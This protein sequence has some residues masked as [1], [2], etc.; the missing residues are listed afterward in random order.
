MKIRT[1]QL[2]HLQQQ[3]TARAKAK[4]ETG[5]FEDLLASEVDKAAD[6]QGVQQTSTPPPGA[7]LGIESLLGVEAL[8]ATDAITPSEQSVMENIDTVLDK[9]ETYAENLNAPES[10]SGL[11]TA[12]GVLQNISDDVQ[13]LKDAMP[14]LAE[15]RPDLQGLVDELEILTVTEQFKFNRGD[16]L[17]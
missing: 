1:D 13:D 5:G 4:A 17:A 7:R 10:E 8:D 6:S 12:Y 15:S 11:R 3:E 16:Y 14:A 9:W 2:E